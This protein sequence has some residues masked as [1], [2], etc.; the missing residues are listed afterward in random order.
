MDQPSDEKKKSQEEQPPA[1]HKEQPKKDDGVQ[2]PESA[3]EAKSTGE[4]PEEEP[5]ERPFKIG[6]REVIVGV[7]LLVIGMLVVHNSSSGNGPGEENRPRCLGPTTRS[8]ACRQS[9]R[10]AASLTADT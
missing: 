2:P 8:L 7:I 10:S 6:L 3:T 5:K 1:P 4:E 9:A